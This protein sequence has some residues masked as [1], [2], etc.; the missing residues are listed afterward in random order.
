MQF[1]RSDEEN[2]GDESD[3]PLMIIPEPEPVVR[4][5]EG[6]RGLHNTQLASSQAPDRAMDDGG[7]GKSGW[8]SSMGLEG[9]REHTMITEFEALV[10]KRASFRH[11]QC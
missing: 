5:L 7:P 1:C 3:N 10:H 9:Q 6:C 2:D 4:H 8:L 11:R